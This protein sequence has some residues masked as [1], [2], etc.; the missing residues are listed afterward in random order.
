MSCS[1]L[2]GRFIGCAPQQ[3]VARSLATWDDGLQK[4]EIRFIDKRHH[5]NI[6]VKG[7][8]EHML[9][10]VLAAVRMPN[11]ITQ[12]VRFNCEDNFLEGDAPSS[13]QFRVLTVVPAKGFHLFRLA[14]CVP[15]VT[16]TSGNVGHALVLYELEET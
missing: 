16:S 7:N 1:N 5:K 15:N 11:D 2:S 3:I 8:H 9:V 10:R 13:F 14:R 4:I 12:T 6:T